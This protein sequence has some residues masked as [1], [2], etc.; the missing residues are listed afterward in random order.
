MLSNFVS[1]HKKEL[2]NI[3]LAVRLLSMDAVLKAKSGHIGLPLGGAEMGTLLY[4]AVMRHDPQNPQWLNRDRFVLSAGH[5]S[6]L[7]YSLLHLS[8]YKLPKEEINKFLRDN[9]RELI[10]DFFKEIITIISHCNMHCD[11]KTK[12]SSLV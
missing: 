4:F 7:Q 12:R 6:M 8:G 1:K 9:T 10:Q 2:E 3:A 11:Q 5:G